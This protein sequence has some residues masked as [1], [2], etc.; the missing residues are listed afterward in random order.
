MTSPVDV[1]KAL[2]FCRV[3]AERADKARVLHDIVEGFDFAADAECSILLRMAGDK[4]GQTKNHQKNFI[5]QNPFQNR[6]S[7]D[8]FRS[9]A[10]GF[11]FPSA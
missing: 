4:Q 9:G 7:S 8:H 1:L 10:Q 3:L 11:L 5:H 6:S 2:K